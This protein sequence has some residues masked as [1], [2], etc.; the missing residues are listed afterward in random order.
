[1]NRK[2][3]FTPE[4]V[5]QTNKWAALHAIAEQAGFDDDALAY[6]EFCLMPFF[7]AVVEECAKIAEQQ[8]RVYTGEN[9]ESA[10]CSASASAIRTFGHRIGNYE[11]K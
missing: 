2:N 4:Q 7:E 6:T 10:G 3:K 1:M 8:G 5:Y 11:Q 9:N